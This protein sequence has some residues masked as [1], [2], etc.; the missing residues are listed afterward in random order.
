MILSLLVSPS[1]ALKR[2]AK[3]NS[4]KYSTLPIPR[5]ALLFSLPDLSATSYYC[6]ELQSLHLKMLEELTWGIQKW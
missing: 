1:S 6:R 4:F 3:I 2:K 5:P